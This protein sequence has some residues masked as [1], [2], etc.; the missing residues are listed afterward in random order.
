MGDISKGLANTF[1]PEKN[2]FVVRK[3]SLLLFL[4]QILLRRHEEYSMV[5]PEV[6]NSKKVF[7]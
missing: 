7:N 4:L 1:E 2:L 5:I 3:T 6:L